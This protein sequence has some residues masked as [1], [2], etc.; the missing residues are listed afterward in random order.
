MLRMSR[1]QFIGLVAAGVA[2]TIASPSVARALENDSNQLVVFSEEVAATIAGNFAR[3]MKPGLPL[4][5]GTIIPILNTEG[6]FKGYSVEYLLSGAPSGY[7]V[8][9]VDYPGL[10]ASFSFSEGSLSQGKRVLDE[11]QRS[12]DQRSIMDACLIEMDPFCVGYYDEYSGC[13]ISLDSKSQAKSSLVESL[14]TRANWDEVLISQSEINDGGFTA[15]STKY[16]GELAYIT[17]RMAERGNR[18]YA[19][20]PHALYVIGAALPND[21]MNAPIIPDATSNWSCYNKL[22]DY[23]DTRKSSESNGVIYGSTVSDRLGPAFVRLCAERGTTMRQQ[24]VSDPSFLS[25]VSHINNAEVAVM[26]AG[27]K[28]PEGNSGHFLAANGYA[29]LHRKSDNKVLQCV[30]VFDGWDSHQFFN[31]DFPSYNF[32]NTTFLYRKK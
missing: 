32:K 29:Y 28:T 19:C 13:V 17:Q 25:I 23:S 10:I 1:R 9:E 31:F 15:G 3:S 21:Q 7:A 24:Y 16:S 2:S 30:A 5:V 26:G 20:G 27:I 6:V 12:N 18:R 14:R 4:K 22:W 11:L 8:L